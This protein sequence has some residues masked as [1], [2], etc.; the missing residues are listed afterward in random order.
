M[1][2]I[3]RDDTPASEQVFAGKLF[4]LL[5]AGK[6]IL[7]AGPPRSVVGA[8]LEETGAGLQVHIADP[9]AITAALNKLLQNPPRLSLNSDKL[10]QFSRAELTRQLLLLYP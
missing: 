6:P 8:L 1:N 10:R 3:L 9:Q 2:L 7:S 5:R 4:E